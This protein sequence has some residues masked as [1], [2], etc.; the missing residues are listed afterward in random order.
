MESYNIYR[1]IFIVMVE[2]VDK[3]KDKTNENLPDKLEAE[4][5]V[6]AKSGSNL[7][8][9]TSDGFKFAVAIIVSF[10]TIV[11]NIYE[12]VNNNPI[13]LPDYLIL[14]FFFTLAYTFYVL[15]YLIA[16]IAVKGSSLE[17]QDPVTKKKLG[18][19]S[20][21]LYIQTFDEIPL[22]LIL[23]A[24]VLLMDL[25]DEVENYLGVY[26]YVFIIIL[27]WILF[28][29]YLH[30]RN[31][32]NSTKDCPSKG[33]SRKIIRIA[34]VI[35]DKIAE[36]LDPEDKHIFNNYRDTSI[37][38]INSTLFILIFL[39]IEKYLTNSI[40]VEDIILDVSS[41]L[42]NWHIIV[43]GY[44]FKDKLKD[45]LNIK[46]HNSFTSS[47]PI[48]KQNVMKGDYT[49]ITASGVSLFAIWI[50]FIIFN[51]FIFSHFFTGD[52]KVSM[53]DVNNT[54]ATHIPIQIITTGFCSNLTI[55]LT[56]TDAEGKKSSLDSIVVH[57]TNNA[58]E[59]TLSKYLRSSTLGYGKYKVF[60][61]A[62]NLTQGYYE[63]TFCEDFIDKYYLISKGFS[64]TFGIS[65]SKKAFN[66]FYLA[67]SNK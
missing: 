41:L 19:L 56:K 17:A 45:K 53:D 16:Y 48:L 62:T 67:K 51:V 3:P 11:Y 39:L 32:K 52:I 4:D 37:F 9:D 38:G 20:S 28:I 63:L 22:F 57:P 66:S 5:K 15:L 42:L 50:V 49:S 29:R 26:T 12:Y 8:T 46:T 25:F 33:K 13:I 10:S 7:E 47:I 58:N 61:D 65:S 35:V 40:T 36:R 43:I 64:E 21:Y 44:C 34:V 2:A 54:Y 59:I 55:D 18:N 60:I 27:I 6:V 14:I 30:I 1:L 31:I 23:I 24:A